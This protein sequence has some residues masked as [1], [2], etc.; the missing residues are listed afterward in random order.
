MGSG[1]GIPFNPFLFLR[2]ASGKEAFWKAMPG[3]RNLDIIW[4]PGSI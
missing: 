4:A 3:S 1:A 2:P